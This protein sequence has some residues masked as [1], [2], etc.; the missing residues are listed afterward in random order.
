MQYWPN[1]TPGNIK[2]D[3][4]KKMTR[5]PPETRGGNPNVNA[6]IGTSN[7]EYR[8]GIN[9]KSSGIERGKPVKPFGLYHSS[10]LCD[11]HHPCSGASLKRSSH[12]TALMNL[13]IGN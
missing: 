10:A 11:A 7:Q 9:F 3:A 13:T 1:T 5:I 2:A 12:L 4:Q 8:R 6:D